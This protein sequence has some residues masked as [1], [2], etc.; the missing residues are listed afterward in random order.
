MAYEREEFP[1]VST[2]I[3]RSFPRL[4]FLSQGVSPLQGS[5]IPLITSPFVSPHACV[6]LLLAGSLRGG[7][8]SSGSLRNGESFEEARE[9]FALA[10]SR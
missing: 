6:S 4:G 3:L 8:L 5:L 1:L 10:S 2:L 9:K 7:R